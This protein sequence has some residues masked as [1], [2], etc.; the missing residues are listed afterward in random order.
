MKRR[1][2]LTLV[3]LMVALAILAIIMTA[4]YAVFIS[5]EKATRTAS[6]AGDVFGQGLFILDR[7]SRDLSGAWLPDKAAGSAGIQYRFTGNK[8]SLGFN[9]TAVLSMDEN[10]GPDLVEVSY[11]LS[12]LEDVKTYRLIRR[13]DDTPDD[14]PASGGREVIISDDVVK[15]EFVFV[16]NNEEENWDTQNRSGLPRSVRITLVLADEQGGEETFLT[17]VSLPL[18]E[19]AVPAINLPSGLG[20][21]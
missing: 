18:S 21:L 4:V 3:D 5:Q 13:Q 11:R 15:L 10:S 8:D 9:T 19:P 7:L 2:G 20:L 6:E 16:G 17:L 12:E 1:S 14:D